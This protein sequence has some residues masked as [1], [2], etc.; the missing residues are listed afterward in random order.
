M[1]GRY[2]E[3]KMATHSSILARKFDGQKSLAGCNSYGFIE[4]DR[5]EQLTLSHM[6]VEG[7][8]YTD[9]ERVLGD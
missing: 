2:L 7:V 6:I 9:M 3:K 5:T 1:L 8:T 4:A